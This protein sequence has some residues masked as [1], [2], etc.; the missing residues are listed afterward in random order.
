MPPELRVHEP[1]VFLLLVSPEVGTKKTFDPFPLLPNSF[2][3]YVVSL[4]TPLSTIFLSF[5]LLLGM[6]CALIVPFPR[7]STRRP[8]WREKLLRRSAG[9]RLLYQTWRVLAP[10]VSLTRG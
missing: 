8:P 10:E 9:S 4:E 7:V 6:A 5:L 2:G 1:L 3:R